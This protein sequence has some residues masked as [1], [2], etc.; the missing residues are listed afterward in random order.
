MGHSSDKLLKGIGVASMITCGIG[1]LICFL[2]G[3]IQVVRLPVFLMFLIWFFAG[4]VL[5]AAKR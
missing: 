2:V 5:W 3:G 4:A 1:L